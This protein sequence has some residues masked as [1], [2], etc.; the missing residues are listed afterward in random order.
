MADIQPTETT[1]VPENPKKTQYIL[2]GRQLATQ[3]VNVLKQ[4]Q[5]YD[6]EYNKLGFVEA[7]SDPIT[8]ADLD[9]A[10]AKTFP[11]GAAGSLQISTWNDG[12]YAINKN[13]TDYTGG[14]DISLLK[15][16]S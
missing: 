16:A 9:Y 1:A 15:I 8:Q 6:A 2:N 12:V 5:D 4:A 10:T 14:E 7:G 3:L 11:A 13:G